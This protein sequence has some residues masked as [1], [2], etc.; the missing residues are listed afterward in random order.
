MFFNHD[1]PLRPMMRQQLCL[2]RAGNVLVASALHDPALS[3][4]RT[5]MTIVGP[6]SV[7]AAYASL[8]LVGAIVLGMF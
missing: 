8:I 7:V 6:L 1:F 4:G 3:Q 2:F 5:P